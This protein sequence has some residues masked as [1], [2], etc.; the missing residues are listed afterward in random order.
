[1]LQRLRAGAAGSDEPAGHIEPAKP[2]T[3][4]WG[5][6]SAGADAMEELVT[7]LAPALV[8]QGAE[9]ARA[10]ADDIARARF[11]PVPI[12]AGDVVRGGGGECSTGS[13]LASDV[14]VSLLRTVITE[15]HESEGEGEGEGDSDSGVAEAA[16]PGVLGAD[17]PLDVLAAT[18]RSAAPTIA[19]MD[20]TAAP[21]ITQAAYA[22]WLHAHGAAAV[23]RHG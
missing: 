23:S 16:R 9:A 12:S 20:G 19:A 4:T 21:H 7:E 17:G 5:S 8:R 14:S 13:A 1:M 22:R 18:A 10:I 6:T 15:E 2:D 3:L 11:E